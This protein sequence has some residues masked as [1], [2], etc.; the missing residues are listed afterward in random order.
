MMVLQGTLPA[1]TFGTSTN[2]ATDVLHLPADRCTWTSS[3]ATGGGYKIDK[4]YLILG[5]GS[6]ST[7]TISNPKLGFIGKSGRFVE[8]AL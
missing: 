5:A 8:M 3:A 7:A 2:L 4:A 1:N 6:T